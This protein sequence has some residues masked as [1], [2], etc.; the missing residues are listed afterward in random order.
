[1]KR[2][3]NYMVEKE[4][5]TLIKD[6]NKLEERYPVLQWQI[7][8]PLPVSGSF[9]KVIVLMEVEDGSTTHTDHP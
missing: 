5:D 8:P 6:L 4:L 3:F 9:W 1:M 7:I 2:E